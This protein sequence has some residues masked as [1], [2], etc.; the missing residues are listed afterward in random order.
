MQDVLL[1]KYGEIALRGKNRGKIENSLIATIIKNLKTIGNYWV[2]K[3]QGRILIESLE[4]N[5]Y[6]D[7]ERVI[8]LVSNILGITAVCPAIKIKNE[9]LESIKK[10]SFFHMEKFYVNEKV[11]FKVITKRSDK[12]YPLTSMEISSEI[13][14]YILNNMENLKVDVREPDVKLTIEIRNSIYIY[15]KIIKGFGGL[16]IGESGK[17][18]LLLSGGI[19]SPV[20]GFMMAK[21][22]VSINAVYFDSPPYTSNRAKQKVMDLAEKLAMFTGSIKL[23]IVP[24]TEIQL[25]IYESVPPEKMTIILKRAMIKIAEKIAINTGALGLITGDS[26]GQVA[27]QTMHSID[28]ISSASNKLPIFRPLCGMDKQEIV[29]I[30]REI[31]T[32]DISVRPFEDCC[33]IFVAKH[34]ETKPKKSIIESVEKNIT[35]LDEMIE[36]VIQKLEILDF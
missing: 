14:E 3:E 31:G 6:F 29:D 26:V 12:K 15:S 10:L 33:T 4:K 36:E 23:F 11:T 25:K 9:G 5:N 35:C 30:A 13:G 2:S 17:G 21:R 34:P 24:F 22:G 1:V 32:F 19:D 27:S 16:P 8:P 7:F 20:A 18:T 28:A